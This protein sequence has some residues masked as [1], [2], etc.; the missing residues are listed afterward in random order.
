MKCCVFI[1]IQ[2][3]V[4]SILP[5]ISS[6]T[7]GLFGSILFHFQVLGDFPG[8]CL[9][10]IPNL[11]VIQDYILY[12]L[13]YFKFIET[14]FM[15]QNM[16]W[17]FNRH[18]MCTWKKCVCAVVERCSRNCWLS[19][20]IDSVVQVFILTYF[21]FIYSVGYWGVVL[22]SLT[23]IMDFSVSPFIY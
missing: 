11:I 19:E 18:S 8:V 3:K 17:I 10:L 20:F 14:C 15:A 22:K 2:F 13:N 16:V 7:Y 23:V 1:F 6:L 21:S 9:L 12:N 4:L 5:L